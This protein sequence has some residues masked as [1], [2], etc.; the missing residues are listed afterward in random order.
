MKL[1]TNG[2]QI[3]VSDSILTG[4]TSLSSSGTPGE[5]LIDAMAGA[6]PVDTLVQL[7]NVTAS[8]DVIRARSYNSGERDALVITGGRYDAASAIKF[9]AEGVSKL[10]FVGNVALNTPDAALAG[11]IVQ[12][13]AGGTV[14]GSGRV[15]VYADDHRYNTSPTSGGTQYGNIRANGGSGSP[16]PSKFEA[17]PGF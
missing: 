12:V 2:S 14:T 8:A 1:T 13:D 17:R 15:V 9:Y 16:T 11:K 4:G 5:I 6:S 10:R 7:N 3:Q